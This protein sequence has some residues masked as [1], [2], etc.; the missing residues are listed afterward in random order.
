VNLF[1]QVPFTGLLL[2]DS[3]VSEQD[4]FSFRLVLCTVIAAK[5]FPEP[6][7]ASSI[8]FRCVKELSVPGSG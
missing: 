1:R 7:Y 8:P 4:L 3:E 6:D 2:P 5:F